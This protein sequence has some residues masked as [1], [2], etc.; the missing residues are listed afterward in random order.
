MDR[1]AL[2]ISLQHQNTGSFESSRI[3]LNYDCSVDTCGNLVEENAF[4]SK[5]AKTVH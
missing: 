2:G 3:I 4:C 5:L 1:S